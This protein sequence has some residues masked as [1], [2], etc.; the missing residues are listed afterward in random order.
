MATTAV[1]NRKVVSHAEW[2]AARK[3]FLK[4][5][6][7]FTRLRDELSKQRREL[8]WERVEKK[9]VFDGPTGKESLAD[10]FAG[11]S[12]LIVYHFML[13][14]DWVEGCPSCSF[15]A[16]HFDGAIPHLNARDVTFLAISRA[17]LPQI[18]AFQKRMGWKFKW[19]SS[20]G[21][22][23]NFDYKVSFT[24]E[25][26]EK[27]RGELQLRHDSISTRR[28]ARPQRVLQ[29]SSRN[30]L[31]HLLD[32]RARTRYEHRRVPLPRSRS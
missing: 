21:T 10:L 2:L 20:N 13:G 4:R 25:D 17:P 22:D 9:Y 8:P 28:R 11:R 6:K 32:F 29:G 24:P 14:P 31:S 30:C 1:V 27:R 18:Q 19:V 3:A 12:Q 5:E 7:E 23:F 16:D 15:L 26:I